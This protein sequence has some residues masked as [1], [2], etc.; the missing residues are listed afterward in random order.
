MIHT[1]QFIYYHSYDKCRWHHKGK[2][3]NKLLQLQLQLLQSQAAI[4][5]L[6]VLPRGFEVLKLQQSMVSQHIDLC[7]WTSKTIYD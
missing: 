3:F 7:D 1:I 2:I 5:Q 6:T 4:T